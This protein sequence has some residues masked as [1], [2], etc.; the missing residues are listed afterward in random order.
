MNVKI[1]IA[2]LSASVVTMLL[3]MWWAESMVPF[4][5]VVVL[6]VVSGI[7]FTA[8]LLNVLSDQ[9]LSKQKNG[10]RLLSMS[11]QHQ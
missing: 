6:M 4:G 10:Q 8:C 9:K 1:F 2:R 7:V 3:L 11:T 5:A